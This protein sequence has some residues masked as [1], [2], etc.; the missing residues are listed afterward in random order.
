MDFSMNRHKPRPDMMVQGAI[1]RP[2]STHRFLGVILDQEL[3]WKAQIDNAVARGISYV[4]QPTKWDH[5]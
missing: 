4:L 5:P 2:S 3:R 1:I